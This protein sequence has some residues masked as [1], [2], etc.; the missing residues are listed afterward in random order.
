[1]TPATEPSKALPAPQPL[2]GATWRGD[3]GGALGDLGTLLPFLVGFIVVAG[4]QPTAILLAFGLSLVIVGWHFGV[5]M[6]VQPMKAVGAAALA[7]TA[8]G[9]NDMPAVLAL[10]ALLTGLFWLIAAWSGLARWLAR[11]VSRDVIHGIVLGLGIALIVAGLRRIE[12]DAVLGS[13]SVVLALMLL[14][15]AGWLTMPVVMAIG[16]AVGGW[17]QPELLQAVAETAWALTL[18]A[19]QWPALSQPALWLAAIGLAAAQIPLTFGNAI[20]G[21]VAETR[22]LFPAVAVDESRMARG[23]GFMNLLAAGLGAPPMCFGAGGMAAQ[24]AC[25][26]R[27]GRAPMFLGAALLLAALFA[28]AQLTLL[29]GMLPAGTIGAM[30][31]VAGFS[32]TIGTAGSS[33]DKEA[34]A[35]LLTTA[36]VSVWNAG[37]GVVVGVLLEAGLRARVLRI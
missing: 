4:V 22:R 15:R 1:M 7:H 32:L 8:V 6:P 16:L 20:L 17:R 30:L 12:G 37:V 21:I 35:V 31:L 13:A 11:H 18:P 28:S 23:T 26:A 25:G 10:A 14:G 36:A 9:T 24:V 2:S 19:P 27:T 33:R 34:R 3:L 5:P 29:L